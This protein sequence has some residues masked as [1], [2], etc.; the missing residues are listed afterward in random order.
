MDKYTVVLGELNKWLLERGPNIVTYTN[1]PAI[2]SRLKKTYGKGFP[3]HVV[4]P[5][6]S[7][8]AGDTLIRRYNGIILIDELSPTKENPDANTDNN[9]G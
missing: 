1:S 4:K 2:A 5:E 9:D 8:Y 3:V 7:Y 6:E